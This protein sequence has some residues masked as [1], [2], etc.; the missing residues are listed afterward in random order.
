[1]VDGSACRRCG[2]LAPQVQIS[3]FGGQTN[4]LHHLRH[5]GNLPR[6]GPDPRMNPRCQR[7]IPVRGRAM[8][9]FFERS[10]SQR[11]LKIGF[12][13]CKLERRCNLT[14][15]CLSASACLSPISAPE[16]VSSRIAPLVCPTHPAAVTFWSSPH[17]Q[18]CKLI[19]LVS[20]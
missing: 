2:A 18:L 4:R 7:G 20:F 12:R 14:R 6:R 9:R 13:T 8:S 17:H 10:L 3:A 19:R 16:D 5:M 1:V 15:V 11:E